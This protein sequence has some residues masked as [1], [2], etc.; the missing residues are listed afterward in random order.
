MSNQNKMT[1]QARDSQVIA[2][3]QKDLKTVSS[4]SL[5]GTTFTTITLVAL[6][7]SRVDAINAVAAARASWLAAVAALETLSKQV[8]AVEKGLK[9]YVF[10]L[11]GETSP[12]IADFGFTAPKQ[13]TPTVAV[14]QLAAQKRAATRTAR[15]T[16]G[17]KEK[18]K[19]KGTVTPPVQPAT[20]SAPA[21]TPT[22]PVASPAPN[23]TAPQAVVPAAPKS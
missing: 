9:A 11:F 16:M 3:I 20:A 7:Q 6:I 2:G 22:P 8:N 14:K 5:A 12:L 4:L 18:A 21:T 19:I 10:N 17:K 1:I 23:A 13:T 15:N